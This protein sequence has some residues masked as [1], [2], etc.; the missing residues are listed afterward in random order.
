[1]VFQPMRRQ[2]KAL[3]RDKA[4]ELLRVAIVGRLGTGGTNGYPLVTPMHFCF[5]D[6]KIILHSA[7]KGNKLDNI[8]KHSKV[9]FEIDVLK[10]ILEAPNPCKYSTSYASVM[11]F[12]EAELVIERAN[13][14]YYLK[15]IAEKYSKQSIDNL[16]QE[17]VNKTS[18]IIINI[19][20]ISG[21]FHG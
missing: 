7:L 5:H 18:V 9:C 3:S 10:E 21:R 6:D 13:K 8:K 20:H 4:E 16:G 12:G 2:E 1:M 17:Q 11:V 14:Q 15:L 19:D